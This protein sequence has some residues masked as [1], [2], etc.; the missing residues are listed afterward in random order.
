[1]MLNRANGPPAKFYLGDSIR[2]E[3]PRLIPTWEKDLTL[4]PLCLFNADSLLVALKLEYPYK[5]CLI[6]HLPRF[7]SE[8]ENM[9]EHFL[10]YT[11]LHTW[12]DKQS[13]TGFANY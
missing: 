10:I 12:K 6:V 1:M 8:S 4:T 2:S 11:I 7:S 13:T 3:M 9:C 5:W